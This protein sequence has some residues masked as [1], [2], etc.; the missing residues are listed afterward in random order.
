MLDLERAWNIQGT[1]GSSVTV[2]VLRTVARDPLRRAPA[3]TATGDFA[4]PDDNADAT[5][6]GF[7]LRAWAEVRVMT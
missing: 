3:G 7:L 6:A 2:A 5:S 4:G 1:A